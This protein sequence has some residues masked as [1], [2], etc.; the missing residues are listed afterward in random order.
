MTYS[1][2][3]EG[4]NP[5]IEIPKETGL[6]SVELINYTEVGNFEASGLVSTVRDPEKLQFYSPEKYEFMQQEVFSGHE[7]RPAI[8]GYLDWDSWGRQIEVTSNGTW[9]VATGEK[10]A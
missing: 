2:T 6:N 1:Y 9:V 7:Y 3:G 8:L 5:L 4:I 10:I